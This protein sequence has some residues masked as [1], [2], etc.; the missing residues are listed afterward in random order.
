MRCRSLAVRYVM[1]AVIVGAC[2][3]WA[4]PPIDAHADQEKRVLVLHSYHKGLSWTEKVVSGIESEFAKAAAGGVRA[5]IDYEY[6]DTKRFVDDAYFKILFDLYRHKSKKLR[7]HVIISVDDAA[8]VFLKRYRDRLY[9]EVPVVFCGVNFFTDDMLRGHKRYTGVVEAFDV[10]ATL[11]LALSLHPN[12][13]EFVV[14]GDN[15]I[16]SQSNV[17][18]LSAVAPVYLKK[19]VGMRFLTDADIWRYARELER[20]GPGSVIIAMLFNLDNEG[21]FYTY[22]ESFEIYTQYAKVPVYTYWDF[23]LGYGAVGGKIISGVTQGEEAA[24]KAIQVLRGEKVQHIPILKESP[25]RYMFDYKVLRFYGIGES[26]LPPNSIIINKPHELIDTFHRHKFLIM[27]ILA[28]ILFLIGVIITLSVNIVRRKRVERELVRTNAA[29]DRFVPH[30]FLNNLAKESIIDVQLGDQVQ[31]DM[32]V[33]FSDIRSFTTLSE[34]MSPEENFN[35]IN[36]FLRAIGPIIRTHHGFI[37]KYIGDAIMALFPRD[38]EHAIMAAVEMQKGLIDWNASRRERGF[39]PVEIGIGLHIGTL[40]LGTVG[41]E[42]RMEGTVISDAVNLASRL[43]GLTK[44]FGAGIILSERTLEGLG[45]KKVKYLYR[46]LGRV[47][48]KGKRDPVTIYEIIDGS[49]NAVAERKLK[50]KKLFEQGLD[51]YYA[52][53]FAAAQGKFQ[54]V[55]KL[56]PDDAAARLYERYAVELAQSPPPDD[57]DGVQRLDTK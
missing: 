19:N 6:M 30:E 2:A 8:L 10:R 32:T 45:E 17:K 14:V 24:K 11:D 34:A 29:Y 27:G 53:D 4:L 21:K 39:L 46:N 38:A 12:T 1:C 50:T 20:L 26:K 42:K 52:R 9:G 37:D 15:T 33:L 36:S 47:S 13:K 41:E 49:D 18:A 28:F 35:F 31:K 54:N 48:V 44:L 43:E 5:T 40:M 7:Y 16:T 22:E 3:W 56:N 25:N 55:L 51:L 23:Y 57:W